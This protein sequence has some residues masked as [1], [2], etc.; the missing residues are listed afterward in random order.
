MKSELKS[1][2]K[3]MGLQNRVFL[4]GI[5]KD[6]PDFLSQGNALVLSSQWEGLPNVVLEAMAAGLP[7]VAT[8]TGGVRELVSDGE[9]GFLAPSQE[10]MLLAEAMAHLMKLTEQ[11]RKKMGR[12]GRKIAQE[13]YNIEFIAKKWE[14]L[15][16]EV[17]SM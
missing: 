4:I 13:K 1:K 15:Y 17:L 9:N 11:K 10:P 12:K 7:I 8:D 6:I 2:I 16:E 3:K 5:C 14:A